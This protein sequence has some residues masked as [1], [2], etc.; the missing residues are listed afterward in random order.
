MKQTIEA[1][2]HH[3]QETLKDSKASHDWEHIQRVHTLCMHIGQAEGADLEV[4]E[5]A[6]YLHDIARAEQDASKGRI[7]HARRGAELAREILTEYPI[8][9]EKKENIVHCI[10]AHRF[11]ENHEPETLEAKILFDADKLDSIGSVGIAR[12]FLFAG[13]VGARLH[14]GDVDI[15]K[16]ESYSREDTGYREYKIKLSKIKDC[17]LTEEGKR[18]AQGRHEFMESFFDRFIAEHQGIK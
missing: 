8:P 18:L 15:E 4:L 17:M 12:A 2:R 10:R 16:T 6:A 14:N 11:R 1:I 7:C 13:E 9:K 3:V 5:I